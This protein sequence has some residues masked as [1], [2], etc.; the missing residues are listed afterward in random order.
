MRF[1][2]PLLASGPLR[3]KAEYD[4]RTF[5]ASCVLLTSTWYP[6]AANNPAKAQNTPMLELSVSPIVD[7][8]TPT[9]IGTKL[10]HSRRGRTT[11]ICRE[12]T[13]KDSMSR[14]VM[15]GLQYLDEYVTTTS[16]FGLG[17]AQRGHRYTQPPV[18]KHHQWQVHQHSMLFHQN[19]AYNF[20]GKAD[21]S[22][23]CAGELQRI[24]TPSVEATAPCR[25][26]LESVSYVS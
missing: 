13:R 3:R 11:Y 22:L 7:N 6:A 8:E 1:Y 23:S 10:I 12:P 9:Q 14:R 15:S 17:A 16:K 4:S 5:S 25:A 24:S 26:T 18:R 19:W 2:F 20:E 21:D